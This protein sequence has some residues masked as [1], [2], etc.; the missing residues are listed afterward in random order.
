VI[1]HT[2]QRIRTERCVL[3]DRGTFGDGPFNTAQDFT[4]Y[5]RCISR[6]I[7]GSS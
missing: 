6:G 2:P 7:V 5:H 3:R 4:L 1:R